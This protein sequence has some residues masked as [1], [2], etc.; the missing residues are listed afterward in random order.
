MV[1]P[2]IEAAQATLAEAERGVAAARADV[3]ARI[4]AMLPDWA[5][6]IGKAFVVTWPDHAQAAGAAGVAAFKQA[7]REWA[8]ARNP[9]LEWPDIYHGEAGVQARDLRARVRSYNA[10]WREELLVLA[11]AHGFTGVPE[12]KQKIEIGQTTY[13]IPVPDDLTAWTAAENAV[14]SAQRELNAVKSRLAQVDAAAMWD[15]A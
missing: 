2:E 11:R 13:E 12:Y 14:L 5:M 1:D 8:E 10:E 4:R 3:A 15:Q 9:V 6:G 7:L